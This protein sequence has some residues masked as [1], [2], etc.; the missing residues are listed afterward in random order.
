[1]GTVKLVGADVKVLTGS[2]V[3][4]A[5]ISDNSVRASG[6]IEAN[7]GF[8]LGTLHAGSVLNGAQAGK[9]QVRIVLADDDSQNQR[10]AANAIASRFL[11]FKTSGLEFDV[12]SRAGVTI[13]LS[14]Q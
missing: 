2:H 13:E 6:V 5:L 3:E 10:R 8:K 4:A 1:M 14:P 7:G 12:P 11:D 9:Y